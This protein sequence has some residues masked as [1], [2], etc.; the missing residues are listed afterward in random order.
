MIGVRGLVG[1][2]QICMEP[3]YGYSVS[4]HAGATLG[5]TA[6][7]PQEYPESSLG[8]TRASAVDGQN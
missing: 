2:R 8:P 1:A 3:C 5:K 4:L 6:V 7:P